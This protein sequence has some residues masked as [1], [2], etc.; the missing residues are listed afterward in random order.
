[1]G[2]TTCRIVAVRRELVQASS[3]GI[4]CRRQ[5]CASVA[6][7]PCPQQRQ[8]QFAASVRHVWCR[9][10]CNAESVWSASEPYSMLSAAYGHQR[11]WLTK[12]H[13]GLLAMW[14]AY[15]E[16]TGRWRSTSCRMVT[17]WYGKAASWYQ[18]TTN[19][20]AG[21]RSAGN[22]LS[23]GRRTKYGYRRLPAFQIH[24]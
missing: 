10:N 5:P 20:F 21:V 13:A 2:R 12:P 23:N 4:R 17:W 3:S 18:R 16:G 8:A 24:A 9:W 1:M 22:T 19:R 15:V 7:C 6:A 11:C 14:Q